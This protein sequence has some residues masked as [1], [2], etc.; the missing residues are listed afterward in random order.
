MCIYESLYATHTTETY[1]KYIDIYAEA[2]IPTFFCLQH[3]Q[4]YEEI[5]IHYQCKWWKH[6]ARMEDRLPLLA[7][8]Y[9]SGHSDLGTLKQRREDEEHQVLEEQALMDLKGDSS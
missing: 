4:F 3:L 1:T 5:L 8:H 9:P 2:N 6:V 7:F